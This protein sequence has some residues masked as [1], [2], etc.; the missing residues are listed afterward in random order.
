MVFLYTELT[1][2][3]S[4]FH[5]RVNR[6]VH[7]RVCFWKDVLGRNQVSGLVNSRVHPVKPPLVGLRVHSLESTCP[8]NQQVWDTG[9]FSKD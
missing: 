5:Q 1:N 7:P 2:L 6:T 3:R 9:F 8:V 4:H